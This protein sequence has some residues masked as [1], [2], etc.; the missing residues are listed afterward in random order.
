MK[1]WTPAAVLVAAAALVVGTAL[2]AHAATTTIAVPD[3]A[4]SVAV[5]VVTGRAYVSTA[6]TPPAGTDPPPSWDYGLGIAQVDVKSKK[7]VKAVTLLTITASSTIAAGVADVEVS[8]VSNDLWVLVGFNGSG[9]LCLATLYQ[10]DKRTL[11]TVRQHR[12]GCARKIELDPTS[13]WAYLTEAPFYDDRGENAQPLAPATVVAINGA[14]GDVRRAEAPASAAPVFSVTVRYL[15]SSIAFNRRTNQLYLVGQSTAWVFT[16]KLA[17]V[18]TIPLD[19]PAEAALSV[20]ANPVSNQVYVADRARVTEISGRTGKVTR[21][22]GLAGDSTMVIDIGAN[23]LY[24]GTNTVKLSTLRS[25]G[26]QPRVVQAVHPLTHARY[27]TGLGN[28]YVD[29]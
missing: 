4:G 7:V 2:P 5:D 19:H 15:P 13:R 21:T 3:G 18:R 12:V 27:S 25:V 28:L 26:Q 6:P 29:R 23:V 1:K 22:A 14:S 17:L 16:T 24:R 8:S 9:E 11:A 20:A 10:L